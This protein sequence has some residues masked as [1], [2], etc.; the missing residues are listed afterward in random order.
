M[1]MTAITI[2]IVKATLVILLFMHLNRARPGAQAGSGRV[3][4]ETQ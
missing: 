3:R 2:A 1:V 4:K